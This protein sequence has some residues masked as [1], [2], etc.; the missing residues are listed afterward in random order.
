MEELGQLKRIESKYNSSQYWIE[1]GMKIFIEPDVEEDLEVL[2]GFTKVCRDEDARLVLA[3]V[4]EMSAA[5]PRL[6]WLVYD[7][8]GLTNN[9]WLKL[10]AGEFRG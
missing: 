7:E 1:W 5:T 3:A 6:T 10:K 4:K 2:C 8:G 9:M